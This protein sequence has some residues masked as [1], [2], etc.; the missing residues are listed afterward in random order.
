MKQSIIRRLYVNVKKAYPRDALPTI[1]RDAGEALALR[2][3]L[4][5]HEQGET[6]EKITSEVKKIMAEA[7]ASRPPPRQASMQASGSVTTRDQVADCAAS[8][9]D[10]F[11]KVLPSGWRRPPCRDTKQ[12]REAYPTAD[13][14]P[15]RDPVRLYSSMWRGVRRDVRLATGSASDPA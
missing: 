14:R 6:P 11:S 10:Y 12:P 7:L 2:R 15:Q 4:T 1:T 8:T 5:M 3:A 13:R 9:D